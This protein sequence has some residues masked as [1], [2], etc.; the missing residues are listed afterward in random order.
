MYF[1]TNLDGVFD[2]SPQQIFSDC[3]K[4]SRA[5][6]SRINGQETG[7]LSLDSDGWVTSLLPGQDA[8]TYIST[9]EFYPTGNYTFTW[10]GEGD[11]QIEFVEHS[12][13]SSAPNR[14][15]INI[16]KNQYTTFALSIKQ[17]NP[18]N[19]LR[20][21]RVYLP[22]KDE[23]SPLFNP[24]F[25]AALDGV[26]CIRLMDLAHTNHN[27]LVNWA[28]RPK[29]T[30]A[31]WSSSKG[32]PIEA[33]IELVNLTNADAWYCIP[34]AA[35]DNFI[36][37][38]AA[39]WRDGLEAGRK[40]Y[41]E[42]SNEI[43]NGMF[44]Q[45]QYA[46]AQAESTPDLPDGF[47][48]AACWNGRRA[49][50]MF[51]LWQIAF[52]ANFSSRVVRCLGSQVANSWVV[53]QSLKQDN[54]Y[55]MTDMIAV[56]PYFNPYTPYGNPIETQGLAILAKSPETVLDDFLL[57]IAGA[58]RNVLVSHNADIRNLKIPGTQTPLYNGGFTCYEVGNHLVAEQ[59]NFWEQA[60]QLNKPNL[61]NE[62]DILFTAAMRLPR[63]RTVYRAYIDMIMAAIGTGGFFNQF[64]LIG[65]YTK[66]GYW[67]AKEHL[68]QADADAPKYLA[69]KDAIAGVPTP[70]VARSNAQPFSFTSLGGSNSPSPSPSPSPTPTPTPVS[71]SLNVLRLTSNSSGSR[72][73][74]GVQIN[75]AVSDRIH[76]VYRVRRGTVSFAAPPNGVRIRGNNTSEAIVTGER[77][78]VNSY[79]AANA[80]SL[81]GSNGQ[82]P[83]VAIVSVPALD[84][85]RFAAGASLA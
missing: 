16:G 15:V 84:R 66:Y 79:L 13:V 85:L 27:P 57:A 20:N 59:N 31:R 10:E 30:D 45:H 80:P 26:D 62:L 12:I 11:F 69:L 29:M 35:S 44:A 24:D 63:M 61:I 77:S 56:A 67:G 49:K 68:Y 8:L 22:G 17:T 52:G 81:T 21:L 43:W 78:A 37:Q 60:S 74:G 3:F 65:R 2:W 46:V 39:M 6:T 41:L 36:T 50:Q 53:E 47:E 32:I 9:S 82:S 48:G 4:Q 51:G 83:N 18:A 42:Y 14:K 58:D 72:S 64:V 25:L 38:A 40:I 28:D 19:H 54:C 5:W 1:A 71:S 73:I 7:T 55:E 75:L 76:V 70:N 33:M 34:H 23:N